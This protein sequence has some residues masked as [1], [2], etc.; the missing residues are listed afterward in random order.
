MWEMDFDFMLNQTSNIYTKA[1][2]TKQNSMSQSEQVDGNSKY[3]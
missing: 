3:Y 1:E 2:S